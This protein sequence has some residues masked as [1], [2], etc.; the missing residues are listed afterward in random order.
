MSRSSTY[1]ESYNRAL[2]LICARGKSKEL[3]TEVAL[4]LQWSV[5]R[6]TVRGILSGLHDIGIIEWSG[7][8]KKILRKPR[9]N[10]YYPEE[11]TASNADRLPS[12]FM[13]YIFAGELNPGATLN[14]SELA[15]YFDVSSTVVR[16]F[17]IRFSRFG[18]IEKKPNRHW[19]LNGFT[20]EFADELF[21]VR[22]LFERRAFQSFLNADKQEHQK[23]IALKSDHALMLKNI[24]NEFMQFPRLDEQFHR[25][26]VDAFGNRFVQD[27]F[28][29]ISLV[30]H[31][32]YRWNK[33]D[34]M[35]R[36]RIAI[37]Q[38]LKIIV[39]IEAGKLD[40]ANAVFLEHLSHAKES[41]IASVA[42]DVSNSHTHYVQCI[43]KQRTDSL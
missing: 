11:E 40:E 41:L 16:E 37:K 5:S 27:F 2:D 12:L 25:I 19:V 18:L 22:E 24:K 15:K 7:R 38:H 4:S 1:K 8:T 26:W 35:Q 36:N 23:V 43:T 13:D 29:L 34:E 33:I 21:T 9:T 42:W 31:Y 17:L 3:P 32:H 14:E 6:T 20:R 39:A 10:D 30:F 28:E